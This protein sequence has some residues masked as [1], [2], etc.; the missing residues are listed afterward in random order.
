MSFRITLEVMCPSDW[1]EDYE[2]LVMAVLQR[3][4]GQ[5]VSKSNV[6]VI[7]VKELRAW[8]KLVSDIVKQQN[9]P[10][11]REMLKELIE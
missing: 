11:L 2:N 5:C 3:E 7:E 9:G 6:E 1:N 4:M 8:K 10:H